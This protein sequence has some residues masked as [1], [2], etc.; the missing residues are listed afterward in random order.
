VIV[1]ELD[2]NGGRYGRY[3]HI[4]VVF[5]ANTTQ[6]SFTSTALAGLDLG[7]HPVQR[8]SSDAVVRTA[9]FDEKTGTVVVPGLTTAVFVTGGER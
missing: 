7:L 6:Q 8:S 3:D 2:E 5:N 9:S 4:V 1:M